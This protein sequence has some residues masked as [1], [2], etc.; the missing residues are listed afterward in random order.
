MRPPSKCLAMCVNT[1]VGT[2]LQTTHTN[3]TNVLC[4]VQKWQC[5]VMGCSFFVENAE[6]CT[7]SRWRH[8][9]SSARLAVVPTEWKNTAHTAEIP[10]HVL[11]TLFPGKLISRTGESPGHSLAWSCST[12]VYFFW[13]YV[14]SSVCGTC[15]ARIDDL[16]ESS[17]ECVQGIPKEMQQLVVTAFPSRLRT[18]RY[19]D[20]LQ[21]VILKQ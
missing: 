20:H 4:A 15:R 6:S 7:K 13:G 10:M 3:R 1:V 19:S 14:R 21:S 17:R 11:R 12:G 18:E 8:T 5:G 2:G 9:S 16:T